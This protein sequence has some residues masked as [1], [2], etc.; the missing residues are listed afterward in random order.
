MDKSRMSTFLTCI[1]A[2]GVVATAV[3]T[4]KATP[5]ATVAIIDAKCE[6]E[7]FELTKIEKIKAAA[8]AYIPAIITGASTIACIFGA[9][10]LNKQSQA[11]LVSAYA[12]LDRTYREYTK[13]VKELYGEE[14]DH[15]VKEE[16]AK[17]HYTDQESTIPKG[18]QLFYDLNTMQYFA[19]SIDD[20][21]QKTVM[22]DGLECYIISTPFDVMPRF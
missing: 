9:N 13:K 19:A 8:P 7:D 15:R 4:A 16:M 14:I 21:L 18:E 12:M 1:G 20:V 17:E 11:S 10:V 5:K 2:I 3:L 22:D 6:K